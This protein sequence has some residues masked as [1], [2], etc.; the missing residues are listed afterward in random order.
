MTSIPYD[1]DPCLDQDDTGKYDLNLH[2]LALAVMLASSL[3]GVCFPVIIKY[4]GWSKVTRALRVGKYFGAGVIT[5]TGFVHIFPTA[6]QN[7]TNECLPIFFSDSFRG[8][9]GLF[10]MS[11]TLL[12]HLIEYLATNKTSK[13]VEFHSH[14][15]LLENKQ[16]VSTYILQFSIILHS[17][18][19]G[20]DLG[21]TTTKLLTLLVALTFHQFF[22]GIG[23]G[24]RISEIKYKSRFVIIG[25]AM[26]FAL[27]TPI[28]VALGI[29][30]HTLGITDGTGAILLKGI[31]DALASGTMIY[32]SLVSLLVEE[33]R[34]N[35]FGKFPL[36]EKF[37]CYFAMYLGAGMMSVLALW[38][39]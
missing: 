15:L 36:W 10:A 37:V 22:E 2:I 31:L 9:A 32:V 16:V 26:V 17:L 7:L 5:A 30:V 23:I 27:T 13:P 4:M 18:V 39:W 34:S 24:Y 20:A 35:R 29:L 12:V 33:F 6:V 11:G 8:A 1:T 38:A 28:G 25:N 19:I 14:S 3:L 21:V